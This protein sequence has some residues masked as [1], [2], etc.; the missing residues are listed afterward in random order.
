MK[1]RRI[2]SFAAAAAMT[3]SAVPMTAFADDDKGEVMVVIANE[4]FTK[5]AGAAWDGTLLRAVVELD[6]DTTMLSAIIEAVESNGYTISA[7]VSEYGAFISDINGVGETTYAVQE[8]AYPGWNLSLNNWFTN[9]GVSAYSVA[10]GNLKDGDVIGLEYGITGEDVRNIWYSNDTSIK[11]V[12]IGDEQFEEFDPNTFEYTLELDTNELWLLAYPA[13]LV[14]QTRKYINSYTPENET[15]GYRFFDYMEVN[16]G[17]V[18]YVGVGNENWPSSYWGTDPVTESVYKFNIVVKDD[19]ADDQ[20]AADAV[21]ALIDAI[22]EVT[23]DSK[24]DIDNALNAYE[25]LTDAQKALVTNYGV[26]VQAIADYEELQDQPGDLDFDT[27]YDATAARLAQEDAVI[28]NE[29]KIIGLAR[30]GKLTKEQS[31]KMIKA[32]ADYALSAKDG[33]LNDRRS[34]ENSKEAITA[35]AL[36]YDPTNIAG[37]DLLAA[38]KDKDYVSAQ[39]VTGY[40]WANL[41]YTSVGKEAPYVD[42][43]LA[44]QLDNGAFSF[45]GKTADLDIT[46]MALTSLRGIDKAKD[47]FNAGAKWILMTLLLNPDLANNC[48]TISQVTI[49]VCSNFDD[50]SDVMLNIIKEYSDID[51]PEDIPSE[52]SVIKTDGYLDSI[53]RF[54]L[55]NGEFCHILGGK[56][57]GMST[58]QAFLSLEA[59]RRGSSELPALYDFTGEKL[60]PYTTA[61]AEKPDDT[62]PAT[63]AKAAVCVLAV[64]ALASLCIAGKKKKK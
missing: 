12:F 30:A 22:G 62:N 57:D 1:A 46:A 45:D 10:D 48:E 29:W 40:I 31:D 32:I 28:G 58:E 53:G 34:T 42:E 33:K 49:A 4:T 37:V 41:A 17:D 20:A 56:Y 36:G 19:N 38:L 6:D 16:D 44:M 24:D 64:I 50:F 54:Y 3:L 23:L 60:V 11:E 55:G 52:G 35:A 61:P 7:P 25:E 51:F 8:G 9:Q 21:I 13:N 5:E 2:L 43:L 14:F 59:L 39:G 18:V 63:G 27:V 47:A 26:L 15:S